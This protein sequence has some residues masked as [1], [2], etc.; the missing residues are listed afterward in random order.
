M[1]NAEGI[2]THAFKTSQIVEGLNEVFEK[3]RR[4]SPYRLNAK[5]LKWHGKQLEE[6]TNN[7][8]KWIK[9]ARTYNH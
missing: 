1:M 9:E 8:T 6:R 2:A 4:D 3:S 5:I 7:I